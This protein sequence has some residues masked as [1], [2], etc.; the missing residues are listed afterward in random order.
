MTKIYQGDLPQKINVVVERKV[1]AV[2]EFDKNGIYETNNELVIK[3][4]KGYG[5]KVEEIEETPKPRKRAKDI[6]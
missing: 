6:D 1:I 3:E 4:L 2:A 5:Y